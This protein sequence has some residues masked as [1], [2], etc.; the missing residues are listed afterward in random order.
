MRATMIRI[1]L[2]I[3]LCGVVCAADVQ[4]TEYVSDCLARLLHLQQGWGVLGV[5][6]C[7]HL[8]G[9][10]G[11]ALQIGDR[12]YQHGLGHH[13]PGEIV[14]ELAGA[15]ERFEAEVG[16]Q[17]QPGTAG[18][19]VFQ[20]YVDDQKQFDSGVVR[21]G[22]SAGR[23]PCLCGGPR[24]CAWSPRTRAT[25]TFAI[26]PIGRKRGWCATRMPPMLRVNNGQ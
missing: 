6:T 1:A 8:A 22:E 13:A 20:V 10:S 16:V 12:T 14:L 7:A 15:Y 5:D 26:A 3:L 18:T 19:V 17:T 11:L 23:W 4:V 2:M 21:N 25:V 9:Q 24:N